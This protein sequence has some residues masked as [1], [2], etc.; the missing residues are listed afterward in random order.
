MEKL[1][2]V[3]GHRSMRDIR[4]LYLTWSERD[5]GDSMSPSMPHSSP[6]LRRVSLFPQGKLEILMLFY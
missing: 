6:F 3:V 5:S 1:F 4:L 2:G